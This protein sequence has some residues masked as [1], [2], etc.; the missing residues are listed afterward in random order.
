LTAPAAHELEDLERAEAA[1]RELLSALTINDVDILTRSTVL[2]TLDRQPP[3]YR[4]SVA[5]E[6]TAEVDMW[7][8]SFVGSFW[9]PKLKPLIT[10]PWNGVRLTLISVRFP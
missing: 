10:R 6:Y 2:R 5:G 7:R 3:L 1:V 8:V 9:M 4:L